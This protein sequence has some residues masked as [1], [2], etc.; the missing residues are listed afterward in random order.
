MNEPRSR[1]Q[2]VRDALNMFEAE[3]DCWVATAQG[4]TPHLVPLS[5]VWLRGVFHF[6][7][8]SASRTAMNTS[9]GGLVRLAFGT[10]RDVVIVDATTRVMAHSD[11]PPDV[12]DK[13]ARRF[14]WDL[15]GSPEYVAIGARPQRILAWRGDDEMPHRTIMSDGR[16]VGG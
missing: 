3:R 13:F 5:Y 8:P 14:Q 7:T 15:R 6:A 12:I 10:T 1:E 2:R 11:I 9:I 16:W 4:D